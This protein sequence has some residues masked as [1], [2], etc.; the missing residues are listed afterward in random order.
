MFQSF[1]QVVVS[2]LDRNGR[3]WYKNPPDSFVYIF[4]FFIGNC[5][6]CVIVWL[7]SILVNKFTLRSRLLLLFFLPIFFCLF[8]FGNLISANR[9]FCWKRVEG[10]NSGWCQWLICSFCAMNRS[11]SHC[12]GFLQSFTLKTSCPAHYYTSQR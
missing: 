4:P 6:W 11:F 3:G 2:A 8:H 7:V 9:I 10:A 1:I 12:C 5:C